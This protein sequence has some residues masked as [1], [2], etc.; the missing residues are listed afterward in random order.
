M[1]ERPPNK[2][3]LMSVMLA[4]SASPGMCSKAGRP[5]PDASAASSAPTTLSATPS[6]SSS[7]AAAASASASAASAS[8]RAAAVE[9]AKELVADIRWMIAKGVTVNPA[10]AGEGDVATKCD[11]LESMRSSAGGDPDLLAVLD[12]GAA[13]CAFDVP[14]LTA[15]ESLD[16]LRGTPSQASR[17]LMCSV[18]E[19]EIAKARAVRPGDP[20]VR[21]ADARRASTCSKRP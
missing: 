17:L 18:A 14:L 21:N 7:A 11:G 1:L 6:S 8:A 15:S 12:D 19:R 4:L 5:A 2:L 13:L 16:H 10:K 3:P 20:R 9:R